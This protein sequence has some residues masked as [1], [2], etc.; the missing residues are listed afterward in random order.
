MF[1]VNDSG[2]RGTIP[3]G[4]A[5][6]FI[7]QG[8]MIPCADDAVSDA[9][10][11]QRALGMTGLPAAEDSL[12]GYY[13]NVDYGASPMVDGDVGGGLIHASLVTN[14]PTVEAPSPAP[15]PNPKGG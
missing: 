11:V 6:Y 2:T 7:E 12:T 4:A 13:H 1:A 10:Y 9:W 14:D 8:A 15:G 3:Q 5:D